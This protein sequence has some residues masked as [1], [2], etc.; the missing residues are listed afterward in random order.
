ME[1]TRK[2]VTDSREDVSRFVVH[3]TRDDREDFK[4]GA[5][6]RDNFLSIIKQKRIGAFRPHCLHAPQIKGFSRKVRRKFYVSCFTEV[7]LTQLRFLVQRIKGRQVCLEP[8][9]FVFDKRTLIEKGAQP[10]LYINSYSGNDALKKSINRIFELSRKN[11]FEDDLARILPF[12]NAMHEKYDFTWEREWR[13]AGDFH[14]KHSNIVCCVLPSSG[15]EDIREKL[16]QAG[17]AAV[18]PGWTYE[19]IV[20]EMARQQRT[21][22]KVFKA[23]GT[24][25]AKTEK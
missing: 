2:N 3:L 15:Q 10:A 4:Y 24:A 22:K 17:I 8:F 14:F 13:V 21:T 6:A 7:P 12:V 19:Q 5:T 9:G 20:S 1:I 18:S 16:I 11:E 23:A 25:S